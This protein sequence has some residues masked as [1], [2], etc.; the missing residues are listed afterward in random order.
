MKS[1]SFSAGID[2]DLTDCNPIP[3]AFLLDHSMIILS[4]VTLKMDQTEESC[5]LLHHRGLRFKAPDSLLQTI[6]GGG[7]RVDRYFPRDV[8]EFLI[9]T[10][11][12]HS[13]HRKEGELLGMSMFV[14]ESDYVTDMLNPYPLKLGQAPF[15][16]CKENEFLPKY[17]GGI[18]GKD[19][20]WVM[21]PL[22][23][24]R[25]WQYWSSSVIS[26]VY[27][28]DNSWALV[29]FHLTEASVFA[30]LI[31]TVMT[32]EQCFEKKFKVAL[33]QLGGHSWF[34]GTVYLNQFFNSRVVWLEDTILKF[35]RE[36][37]V[38][39]FLKTKTLNTVGVLADDEGQNNS[40]V[41]RMVGFLNDGVYCFFAEVQFCGS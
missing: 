19:T 13:L 41:S 18:I 11:H 16:V 17:P 9:C 21:V 28:S 30:P 1:L 31:R 8:V 10:H 36:T 20:P 6:T 34:R 23:A 35:R 24:F 37:D 33:E 7:L 25:T 40:C 32:S 12:E 5:V 38:T 39:D 26:K 14:I 29:V 4:T 22:R 3:P 2:S 27:H 15:P